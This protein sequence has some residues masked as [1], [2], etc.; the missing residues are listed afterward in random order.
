MKKFVCGVFIAIGLLCIAFPSQITK[1]LPYVLGGTM[2][3][4]GIV[5]GAAYFRCR[6]A[7]AEHSTE[8]AAGLLLFVVGVLCIVHG[9]DSIGPLGVTWAIIGLRK[10]SKSLAKVIQ[11][12]GKGIAFYTSLAEF[13][14]R[15][16]FSTMLL[17][18]PIEK[19]KNHVVLLGFELLAVSI[20]IT[21]RVS[22]ALDAEV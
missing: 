20:R 7:W 15:L 21:K 17:F 1:A 16:T 5:Y 11:S 18:Y 8:L 2:A 10:A 22:P 6:E 3:A 19:F 13:L 9:A 14:A 4:A 12:H